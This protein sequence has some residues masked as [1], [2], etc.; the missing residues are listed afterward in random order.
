LR[1]LI[2]FYLELP[3][4]FNGLSAFA[5]R[6]NDGTYRYKSYQDLISDAIDIAAGLDDILL[7][8]EKAAI[9]ADNAYEWMISSIAITM[10]GAVDVPRAS[11]VTESDITYILNHSEAKILFVENEHVL[12]KVLSLSDHLIFV[13][14]IIVLH[15][16]KDLNV[17]KNKNKSFGI[18]NLID[19]IS[20]GKLKRKTQNY[21]ELIKQKKIMREDLFSL[22]YTS[23]T[24]GTP[25]GVMLSHGN[26]IFQLENL[27][28]KLN[29]GD[30]TL[31]ILPIWHIFERIF[32]IFSMYSGACTYYSSVRTLKDDMK[33]VKPEFMASAPRLWESIYSGIFANVSKSKKG[34][35]IL[36]SGAIALS[37]YHFESLQILKGKDLRLKPISFFH[38]F[39]R[40]IFHLT[41]FLLSLFPFLLADLIV[42]SKIREATGGKLKGSVSGG[43]ALPYHVDQFFNQIGIPVLEGYGMTETAP[44]IAMRTF[45]DIIPGTV[46]KIFPKTYIRLLDIQTGEVFLDTEIG[47]VT[48]GRK[49]EIHVKGNQVMLGY[50]KN[51]EATRKVLSDGW[52]NTGDLGIYTANHRLKIVG[53]SKETIVLLSG[54]NVEPVPIESKILESEWIEQCMVVGQD[55]KYLSALVYPN[56]QQLESLKNRTNKEIDSEL[57]QI[58]ENEVKSKINQ[59]NGFKSFERVIGI[60]ILPKP[61]EMGDELT[62][63][64]SLKRHS[65]TEKY[66]D[67][68]EKIYKD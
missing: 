20:A 5:T 55:K 2:D 30:K 42:L 25:K 32:E 64:L 18:S 12:Q 27:P 16:I 52:M 68:I 40:W 3:Q 38:L 46:G 49:G 15:E 65:I 29:A 23:G 50:Y 54:E 21:I 60:F 44:V 45:D 34:K 22:I 58:L 9:F 37:K 35:R 6:S 59:Q 48:Y 8:K 17:I 62:A 57:L 4:R 36:F 47:R 1:T 13:K 39:L 61:F 41:R 66:K 7:E 11:D 43:G 33:K 19:V 63:K 24:T 31:S 51:L 56:P 67:E 10:L 28:L 14:E 26:I 53:R